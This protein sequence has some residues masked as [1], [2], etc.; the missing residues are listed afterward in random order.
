MD[1]NRPLK[2]S[3][4]TEIVEQQSK[5]AAVYHTLCGVASLAGC[6]IGKLE[7]SINGHV[8]E[9]QGNDMTYKGQ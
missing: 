6:K 9:K 5:I 3:Q 7:L 8:F 1:R 2:P 4:V